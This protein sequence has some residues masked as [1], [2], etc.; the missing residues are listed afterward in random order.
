MIIFKNC[1]VFFFSL[2]G[3]LKPS[4]EVRIKTQVGLISKA[5]DTLDVINDDITL[6]SDKILKEQEVLRSKISQKM[7]DRAK[8]SSVKSSNQ[9]LANSLRDKLNN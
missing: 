1:N 8:L 4:P 7:I 2:F 5:L 9:R 3:W 6:K